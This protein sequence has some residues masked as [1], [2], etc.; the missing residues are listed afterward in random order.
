MNRVVSFGE[1]LRE[2]R[3]RL[4]LSQTVFGTKGGVTKKTQMLYE[5]DERS[6]DGVYLAAI[7]MAKADVLYILTGQ[8]SGT[9]TTAVGL[10]MDRF[11]LSVEAVEEGLDATNRTMAPAKKAELFLAVYEMMEEP[12]VTKARVLQLVKLAA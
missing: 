7:A 11:R 6:P 10:D 8:R 4:G 2:E 1:R 3:I 9:A 5:A 12:T